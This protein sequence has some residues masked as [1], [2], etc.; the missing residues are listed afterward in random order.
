M[1][2][3]FAL[4]VGMAGLLS[5]VA[6]IACRTEQSPL[7]PQRHATNPDGDT[8][9]QVTAQM[10]PGPGAPG[11][12]GPGAPAPAGPGDAGT[13]GPGDPGTAGPGDP[14]DSGPGVQDPGTKPPGQSP[15]GAPPRPRPTV[16]GPT[17]TPTVAPCPPTVTLT[18]SGAPMPWDGRQLLKPEEAKYG[19][20][21]II[22][23]LEVTFH[24]TTTTGSV[25]HWSGLYLPPRAYIGV[26]GSNGKVGGCGA[27]GTVMRFPSAS[28]TP[29]PAAVGP[30]LG[31]S[32]CG[33]LI[34]DS[35]GTTPFN[36]LTNP[37]PPFTGT[38]A[39][40]NFDP[41]SDFDYGWYLDS[42]LRFEG[43]D[44]PDELTLQC[45]SLKLTTKVVAAP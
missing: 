10:L 40:T 35:K 26:C 9:G 31:G 36:P 27:I 14:S 32:G 42:E 45:A 25:A 19:P 3:R 33:Q 28:P 11:P 24:A 2:F 6:H 41:N 30:V 4:A 12:A 1:R 44:G 13:A 20:T 15:I 5:V 21:C 22:D 34:F 8:D 18:V 23:R 39:F 38:F 37:P 29:S 7:S 43:F 16:D 17:P